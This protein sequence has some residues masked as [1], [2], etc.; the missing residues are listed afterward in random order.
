MRQ[1]VSVVFQSL[2]GV[3]QA[4]GGPSEDPTGGF[5]LGGWTVPQGDARTEA[6]LGAI[7]ATDHDLLLG[8]RTYD[9]FAGYWPFVAADHPVGQGFNAVAKYVL[10]RGSPRLEW[11]NSHRVADLDGLRRVKATP[12]RDL[13]VWG[14]STLQPQLLAAG[15]VDR[16]VL[17]TYPV[18]LGGGKRLFGAGTPARAMV[19]TEG[20]VSPTGVVIATYRPGGA[21]RTGTHAG[22]DPSA[23]ERARQARIAQNGTW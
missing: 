10:T 23:A 9:I 18:L 4:P 7:F 11:Q 22:P 21:V 16:L 5:G 19:L 12:G 6:A 1:I 3:M 14:S 20:E 13:C 2:D 17:L 8:R 15:L